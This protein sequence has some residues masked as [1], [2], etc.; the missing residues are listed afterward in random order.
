M[1]LPQRTEINRRQI[2]RTLALN[3]EVKKADEDRKKLLDSMQNNER[4]REEVKKLEEQ[5]ADD[6]QIELYKSKEGYVEPSTVDAVIDTAK[7]LGKTESTFPFDIKAALA[8]EKSTTY[9]RSSFW[10][11]RSVT[12]S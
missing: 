11:R 7:R 5:G 4:I 3:D 2:L 1:A 9:P 6:L 8:G 10:N 12:S